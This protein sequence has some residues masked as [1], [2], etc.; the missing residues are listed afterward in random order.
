MGS[1]ALRELVP[2]HVGEKL[3]RGTRPG[4][5]G[6]MPKLAHAKLVPNPTVIPI[7]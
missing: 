7:C 2:V 1:R 4:Q 6:S 5:G 3:A